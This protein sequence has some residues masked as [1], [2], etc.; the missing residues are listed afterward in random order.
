M[1]GTQV[2]S[3]VREL[4]PTLPQWKDPAC[5]NWRSHVLQPSWRSWVLQLRPGAAKEIKK[6]IYIYMLFCFVCLLVAQLCS[7]LCDPTNC[8]WPARL[9]CPWNSPG[10]NTGVD[11]HSLLQGI[12]LTQG[13]N[14]DLLHRRQIF[15]YFKK[16]N[17]VRWLPSWNSFPLCLE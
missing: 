3:L 17:F 13:S 6:I 7:T 2:W 10:K 14:P 9:L 4:D 1:Q 12:F 8:M 5:C 16:Q 11:H 15:S